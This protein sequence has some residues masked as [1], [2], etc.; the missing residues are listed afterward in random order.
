MLF[1]RSLVFNILGYGTLAVGCILTS[2]VGVFSR[3]ATI[4]M[5]TDWF[6]PFVIF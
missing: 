4:R 5:W 6:L 2:I 1:L 3:K